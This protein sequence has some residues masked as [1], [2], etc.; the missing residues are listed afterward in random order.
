MKS[1]SLLGTHNSG[2]YSIKP[3]S[4]IAPD[5]DHGFLR[6]I[7]NFLVT[8]IFFKW[9]VTQWTGFTTQ[10]QNGI[11]YFDLRVAFGTKYCSQTV[12]DDASKIYGCFYFVHGL[13]A[14]RVADEF[15]KIRK[16]LD[17]HPKEVVILDFQHFYAM[18]KQK[19]AIFTRLVEEV[20]RACSLL[21]LL[22]IC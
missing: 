13:Y 18:D 7:P 21:T 9:S 17:E 5:M 19:K 1:S 12:P 20:M 11:R 22:L 4:L 2:S 15:K 6:Y 3:Y 14:S 16:F 10:L 8:P